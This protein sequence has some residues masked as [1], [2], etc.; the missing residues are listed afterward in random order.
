MNIGI[1]VGTINDGIDMG[2]NDRK[3]IHQTQK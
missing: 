3:I 1:G 2:F